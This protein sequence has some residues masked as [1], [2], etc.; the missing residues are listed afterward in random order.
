MEL[1]WCD[2][3]RKIEQ[4]FRAMA[5]TSKKKKKSPTW[6]AFSRLYLDASDLKYFQS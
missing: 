2:V 6:K 4:N 5:L 3:G 1:N